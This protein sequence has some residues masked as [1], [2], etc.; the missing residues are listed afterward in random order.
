[1]IESTPWA[2]GE[3]GSCVKWAGELHHFPLTGLA[4]CGSTRLGRSFVWPR[5][6]ELQS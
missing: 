4:R 5:P 2:S 3:C 1:M 6:K